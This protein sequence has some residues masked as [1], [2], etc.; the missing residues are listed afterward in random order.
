MDQSGLVSAPGPADPAKGKGTLVPVA[1][2]HPNVAT[3]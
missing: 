3:G 2:P 1:V